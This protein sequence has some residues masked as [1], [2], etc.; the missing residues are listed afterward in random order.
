MKPLRT[1]I[2]APTLHQRG[3]GENAPEAQTVGFCDA[4]TALFQLEKDNG[5]KKVVHSSRSLFKLTDSTKPLRDGSRN[6]WK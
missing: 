4:G 3:G 5:K 1:T 2:F 6:S